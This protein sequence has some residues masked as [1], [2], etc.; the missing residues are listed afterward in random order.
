MFESIVASLETFSL[1]FGP[2]GIFI[3]MALESSIIPVPAEA[4]LAAATLLGYT[5]LEV[6]IWGGLGATFGGVIG[7]YI[8]SLGGRPILNK[9]GKYIFIT[10]EKLNGLDSL[11]KKRGNFVVLAGRLIPFIPFKIFSIT[12]GI[13]K[14]DI[15]G[16][17]LFTLIGS[18]PRAFMLSYLG[19]KLLE[20]GN[21]PLM[22]LSMFLLLIIPFAVEG[23]ITRKGK[24]DKNNK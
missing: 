23:W 14:M 4:V 22:I 10:E 9:Y 12:A 3:G 13:A 20:I 6:A 11:F 1:A 5:P 24:K 8:G 7:Y 18:I 16:F 21:V 2:L 15:K 17:T 19:Y